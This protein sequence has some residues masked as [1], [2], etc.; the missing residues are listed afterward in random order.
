MNTTAITTVL[1]TDIADMRAN[2]INR[3][4]TFFVNGKPLPTFGAQQLF[5][6]V[7]SEVGRIPA[8]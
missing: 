5:E 7:R 6:L 4:P 8:S 2:G 1:E 3:T